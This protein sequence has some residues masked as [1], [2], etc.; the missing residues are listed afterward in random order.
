MHVPSKPTAIQLF[1]VVAYSAIFPVTNWMGG[2]IAMVGILATLP[3]LP[4]S[5]VAGMAAVSI[6]K[7]EHSYLVGAGLAVL[8]QAMILLW[9]WNSARSRNNASI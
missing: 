6:T 4:I 7:S 2:P 9:R 8:A 1:L 5:W 3:F